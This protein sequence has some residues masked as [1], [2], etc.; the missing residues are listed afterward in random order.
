M[1]AGLEIWKWFPDD[2]STQKKNPGKAEPAG[3]PAGSASSLIISSQHRDYGPVELYKAK[4]IGWF[5]A[6]GLSSPAHLTN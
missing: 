1:E 4:V 5:K 6:R 2:I 3:R